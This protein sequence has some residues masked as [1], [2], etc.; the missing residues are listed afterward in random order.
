MVSALEVF[1]MPQDTCQRLKHL[2]STRQP[3]ILPTKVK[4][5]VKYFNIVDVC[6]VC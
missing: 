2:I 5:G 4:V 1:D 3:I 6:S